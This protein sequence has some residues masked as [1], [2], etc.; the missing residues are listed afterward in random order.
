MIAEHF[1]VWAGLLSV[2]T[3]LAFNSNGK[4]GW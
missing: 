1:V 4:K 3:L 2:V